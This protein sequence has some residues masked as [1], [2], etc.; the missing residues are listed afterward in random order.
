MLSGN[1]EV[2][3]YL[4]LTIEPIFPGRADVPHGYRAHVMLDCDDMNRALYELSERLAEGG[5]RVVALREAQ[6]DT[7][8]PCLSEQ[9]ELHYLF[10]Q[11]RTRGLAYRIDHADANASDTLRVPAMPEGGEE[12]PEAAALEHESRAALAS[13]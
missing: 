9:A 8:L 10:Q 6:I 2:M 13:G 3:I 1:T 4:Q 11:A 12:R 7:P 5:W